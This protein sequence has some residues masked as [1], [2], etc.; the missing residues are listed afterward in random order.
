MY[1]RTESVPQFLKDN[2]RFCNWKYEQRD[3]RQ[4]EVPYIPGATRQASVDGFSTFMPPIGPPR[5]HSNIRG[6]KN[7]AE[8]VKSHPFTWLYIERHLTR[9]DITRGYRYADPH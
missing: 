4:T 3:G 2:G 1:I 8:M 9:T 7:F 5:S 6:G